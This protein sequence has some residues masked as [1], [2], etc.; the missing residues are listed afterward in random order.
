MKK[1]G[2]VTAVVKERGKKRKKIEPVTEVETDEQKNLL[3]QMQDLQNK[4]EEM[5][6][7]VEDAVE[8]AC[9]GDEECVSGALA[10]IEEAEKGVKR[11]VHTRSISVPPRDFCFTGPEWDTFKLALSER[12]ESNSKQF[13]RNTRLMDKALEQGITRDVPVYKQI[14]TALLQEK[15]AIESLEDFIRK[16]NDADFVCSPQELRDV[17][18]FSEEEI[19]EALEI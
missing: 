7:A 19:E 9:E 14:D 8:I 6:G 2:I 12:K 5:E 17:R 4:I 11:K 10:Q 13:K 1:K 15:E 18:K 3:K 16:Y